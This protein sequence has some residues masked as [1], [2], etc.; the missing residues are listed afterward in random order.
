M[1]IHQVHNTYIHKCKFDYK[2]E[3]QNNLRKKLKLT[4]EKIIHI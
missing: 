1:Y 2:L 3:N 4:T